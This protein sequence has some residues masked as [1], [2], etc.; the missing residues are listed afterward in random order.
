MTDDAGG[1]KSRP[2]ARDR[3]AVLGTLILLGLAT[4]LGTTV[5]SHSRAAPLK[6]AAG[7]IGG[8]YHPIAGTFVPDRT[9]LPDCHRD[10]RCLQQAFGNISYFNGPRYALELFDRLRATDTTV[11]FFCHRIAHMIGSAALARFKGNVAEAY[12][13]GSASCASG[14]YHG[15]LERAF[16][17]VFTDRGLA[18]VARTICR[19]SGVRRFGF[20]DYQCVHGLGHGLMVQT[21][22]DL[23]LSL[24]I[25]ARLQTRWDEVSCTGGVF[26]EN[27]STVY[28]LRSQW[29]KNSDPIFPCNWVTLRDKA[30]C[31]TR[32]TTQIYATNGA[33]WE[34][35]AEACRSLER[36]WQPFCFRSYGRDAVGTSR[37]TGT[38]IVLARCRLAGDGEGDC[39]YGA[40]RTLADANAD[41]GPAASFCRLAPQS[42]QAACFAGIGVVVGLLHATNETRTAACARLTVT[43]ARDCA[44]EARAE[45][46]SNGQGAWG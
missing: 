27:G 2:S 11:T 10:P 42:H 25:C 39:F 29:L 40:A 33:N 46:D 34:K 7:A 32:V 12:S 5:R 43:H 16:I 37:G 44:R 36:T 4:V 26:M 45:I 23:P 35:T 9:K 20:L 3:W 18:R 19:G 15:I 38:D 24:K 14:Y 21:G 6:L 8:S 17:H 31:Y 1:R 41:P 30:S 28:G 22:Y 13:H